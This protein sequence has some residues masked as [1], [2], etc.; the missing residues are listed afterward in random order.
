MDFTEKDKDKDK[1][2]LWYA[3]FSGLISVSNTQFYKL[4]ERCNEQRKQH[5]QSLKKKIIKSPQ[6]KNS[7]NK[8]KTNFRNNKLNI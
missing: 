5:K 7:L 1:P 6:P 2:D 3:I 4:I 8:V